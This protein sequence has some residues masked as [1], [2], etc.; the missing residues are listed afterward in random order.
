MSLSVRIDSGEDKPHHGRPLLV[1]TGERPDPDVLKAMFRP[2]LDDPPWKNKQIRIVGYALG[3]TYRGW[4]VPC[5]TAET[6][7][8][9]FSLEYGRLF[10]RDGVDAVRIADLQ[11]AEF[12]WKRWTVPSKAPRQ[13]KMRYHSAPRCEVV[14]ARAYAKDNDLDCEEAWRYD[15]PWRCY[16]G[17]EAD[18]PHARW[19]KINEGSCDDG[20]IPALI[21][22]V[23]PTC[24][25]A[26]VDYWTEW[27][28]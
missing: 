25:L 9:D 4:L 20:R 12:C 3:G 23:A 11:T 27:Q 18:R 1:I 14:V 15:D 26:V 22:D 8:S 21:A 6:I 7:R 19:L 2:Y 5:P 10:H 13:R 17:E 16:W 24:W 28:C